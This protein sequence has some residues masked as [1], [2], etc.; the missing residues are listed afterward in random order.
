MKQ[1][2][3][4]DMHAVKVA[5]GNNGICKRLRYIFKT[6]DYFHFFKKQPITPAGAK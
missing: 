6:I 2:L 3:M 1:C 4:A 5:D